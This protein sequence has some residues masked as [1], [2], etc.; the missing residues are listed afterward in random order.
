MRDVTTIDWTRPMAKVRSLNPGTQ[1]VFFTQDGIEYDAAGKACNAKQVKEHYAA[2]AAEA[3]KAADEAK[4]QA[5][6]AQSQA[7]EVLKAAGMNKTAA[8]KAAG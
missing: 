2:V 3:Q 6:S 4:E 1:K 7:D 5:A 8:R